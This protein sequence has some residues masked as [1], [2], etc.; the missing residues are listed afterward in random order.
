MIKKISVVLCTY[1]GEK[2][3]K[4]QIDSIINQT[5]PIYELI[6]QDDCSTDATIKIIHEY[7]KKYPLIK[8]Y[9]NKSQLGVSNNFFSAFTK[10]SG[11]FIAIADQDDIWDYEKINVLIS[12]LNGNYLIFSNEIIFDNQEERINKYYNF[13][14]WEN[15]MLSGIAGHLIL[16]NKKILKYLDRVYTSYDWD[17]VIVAAFFQKVTWTPEVLVKWRRHTTAVTVNASE[18]VY[19]K[20]D[21]YLLG[22]KVIFSSQKRKNNLLFLMKFNLLIKN[23]QDEQINLNKIFVYELICN[24]TKNT[25]LHFVRACILSCKNR[26]K[27]YKPLSNKFAYKIKSF[28]FPLFLHLRIWNQLK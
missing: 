9:I 5:Y 12:K 15:L 28:C 13:I 23:L 21:G 4:E 8:V 20:M 16:F 10:T 17:L 25:F 22:L 24:L 1:N 2:F 26:D 7:E 6:I 11:D 18:K 27:L 14:S 3:L 19:T